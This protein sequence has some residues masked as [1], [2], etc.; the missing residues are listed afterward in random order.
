M[1]FTPLDGLPFP[2]ENS[3]KFNYWSMNIFSDINLVSINLESLTVIILF[4]NP[5]KDSFL[6]WD[7]VFAKQAASV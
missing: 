4:V 7:C 6:F 1:I 5:S 3:F 2:P